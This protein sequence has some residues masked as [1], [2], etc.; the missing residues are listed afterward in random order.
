MI[1]KADSDAATICRVSTVPIPQVAV[2]DIDFARV[3]Q[4][5]KQYRHYTSPQ[6]AR[7]TGISIAR[8]DQLLH[9]RP[10]LYREGV[11][12]LELFQRVGGR[13]DYVL[14]ATQE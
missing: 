11:A 9:G 7:A 10:A 5:V 12:L 1:R 14:R 8:I 4:V 6:I 3:L 13:M 2:P